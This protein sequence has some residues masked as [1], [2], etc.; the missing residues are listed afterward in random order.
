MLYDK[1]SIFSD[2]EDDEGKVLLFLP[3]A[4]EVE[5]AE[6][7]WGNEVSSMGRI[8]CINRCQQGTFIF[9]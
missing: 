9:I 4:P 6:E 8:I 1:L 3:I 5:D 7:C 2:E